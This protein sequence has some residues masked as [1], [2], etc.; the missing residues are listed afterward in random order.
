MS[1]A[2]NLDDPAEA[3]AAV[4][5]TPDERA[6]RIAAGLGATA[7]VDEAT[8]DRWLAAQ[9]LDRLP[10]HVSITLSAAQPVIVWRVMGR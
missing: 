5:T 10:G 4:A 2:R 6:G 1:L 9:P 3:V 8:F 7:P